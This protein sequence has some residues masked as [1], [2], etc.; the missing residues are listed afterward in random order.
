MRPTCAICLFLYLVLAMPA[1][2]DPYADGGKAYEAGDNTRALE[3]WKPLA[4][5]GDPRAQYA[6]ANLYFAGLGVKKNQATAA[7]WM[8]RAAEQGLSMAQLLLGNSYREGTG[9][10]KSDRKAVEWWTLAAEQGIP[11]AMY[12]LGVHYYYGR[13]VKKDRVTAFEWYLKAADGGHERAQK[14]IRV[15]PAQDAADQPAAVT[16]P[17]LATSSAAATGSS[18]EPDLLETAPT[19]KSSAP[20]MEATASGVHLSDWIMDQNPEHFTIQLAAMSDED[21]VV[22]YLNKHGIKGEIAIYPRQTSTSTV[23]VIVLGVYT[24]KDSARQ[25]LDQLP[26]ALRKQ[27]IWARPFAEIQAII[28]GSEPFIDKAIN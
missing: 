19:A 22:R 9:V 14:V 6:V 1:Y 25:V 10:Q 7:Y 16:S 2:A 20:S 18:L 21:G 15:E 24:D 4:E 13:G 28:K 26:A 23:F 27:R 5:T 11:D 3:I 8:E 12:N 17:H